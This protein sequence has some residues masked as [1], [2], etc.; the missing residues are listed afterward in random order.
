MTVK[1]LIFN[2]EFSFNVKFKLI[3]YDFDTDVETVLYD[4][5]SGQVVPWSLMYKNVSAINQ[6]EDG[7]I[8]IE[9]I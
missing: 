9:L 3:S 6:G 1:N 4:S 7:T 2:D 5:E 8:E